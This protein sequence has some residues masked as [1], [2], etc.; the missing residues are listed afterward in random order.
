MR[1]GFNWVGYA[2]TRAFGACVWYQ[3]TESMRSLKGFKKIVILVL[4]RYCNLYIELVRKDA[5]ICR[6]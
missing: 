1:L 4:N 6:I 2:E 5:R 3:M